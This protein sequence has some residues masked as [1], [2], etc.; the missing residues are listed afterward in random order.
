MANEIIRPT[1]LPARADPVATEVVPSDNGATVGGVTWADGVNAAVPPATQMES[2]AGVIN[3]KRM[4]PLTTKQAIDAQVPPL[5]SG[6]IGGLGL[7]TMSQ[8]SASD[9]TKTADLAAVALSNDYGDLGNRPTLGSAAATDAADYA[10]AAQGAKADSAVQPSRTVGTGTGLTGG[11]DLSADRTISLTSGAIASLSRADSSVQTVN[12]LTPDGSGNVSVD[13]EFLQEQNSV[14]TAMAES[15]APTVEWVRTAGYAAAGDGG[16][17]LYKRALSEPTHA[18]KF[19]SA[20]GAWWELS[21]EDLYVEV[22]GGGISKS[23]SANTASIASAMSYFSGTGGGSL[24]FR[25]GTYNV[26]SIEN[27]EAILLISGVRLVGG[28]TNSVLRLSASSNGHMINT[29]AGTADVVVESLTL[30][31]NRAQNALAGHGIRSGGIT[32]GVFRNLVI[33]NSCRYGIGVQNGYNENLLFSNIVIEDTGGDGIDIKSKTTET[34]GNPANKAI[35]LENVFV[36]SFGRDA[37]LVASSTQAGIDIRGEVHV[38]NCRVEDV[39]DRKI[40][41]RIRFGETGET[42]G[43]GGH[44]TFINGLYVGGVDVPYKGAGLSIQARSVQAQNIYARNVTVGVEVYQADC[45]VH[46]HVEGC[47][48]GVVCHNTTSGMPSRSDRT[49]ITGNY[50]NC[51]GVG[52]DIIGSQG[53]IVMGCVLRGNG[54]GLRMTGG[55]HVVIGNHSTNNGTPMDNTASGTVVASNYGL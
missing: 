15:F 16:E 51:S 53:C 13:A 54:T 41:V 24:R 43:V 26:N 25:V 37:A 19:Q 17:A 49:K 46:A 8:E 20:D 28:G 36:K 4:T 38:T 32:N 7:D 6:A 40:G 9:Y 12:G 42:N 3:T 5:I 52:I 31:G 50:R 45:D 34:P 44:R 23:A 14:T 11:G 22:F 55:T 30:D 18:G 47:I 35:F 1:Q 33:K 21:G 29:A 39:S 10:T 2:E 27:Q 48:D